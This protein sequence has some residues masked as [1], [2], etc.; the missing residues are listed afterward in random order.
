M[1]FDY[2]K[3]PTEMRNAKRWCLWKIKN[4]D[5]KP[6]KMPI[7]AY[8]GYG[9]KSN[10]ED[11]WC[12]FETA[13]KKCDFFSC[14]GLGFMLGKGFFGVDID[15]ALDNKKLINEFVMCLKSYTEISQSGEGIH[16]VCKGVLPVGARRKGNIEMYDSVRF[17]ALTGNVFEEHKNICDCTESIKEL[18]EKYLNPKPII[19]EGGYDYKKPRYQ[20]KEVTFTKFS[21]SQVINKAL[22]SQNG[23]LFNLLYY[24]QW[25]GVYK[26]QSDA[27]LAFCS[28]LAFWTAKDKVQMDDIF[29]TSKLYRAKWD[30]KH[31]QKTYGEI[32][33]D[34]AI[35]SCRDTY[36]PKQDNEKNIIYNPATGEVKNQKVY[37]LDDTGNALRFVDRFG[38]NIRYN[39]SNKYWVIWDGKTWVE[40]IRQVVKSY[41]DILI[42]EMKEDLISEQDSKTANEIFKNIKRLSSSSGK[43][44]MLKEAQHIGDIPVTNNDFDINKMLLNC[45]NGVVDLASGKLLPHDRKYMISKNTHTNVDLN[46]KCDKWID[47]LRAIFKGSE[48]MIYFIKKAVGYS[49]T[50]STKEQC[51]F[52]CHGNGSNGKSVFFNTIY[53]VFGDYVLNCQVESI[54][55]KN[56]IGSGASSD[57]A[58]MKGARFVR[59]NE[60]TEG[61]R[62]NEGLVKQLTGGDVVTARFLYGKDFEF[63]PEFK[64][65]IACNYKLVVRGTDKGIWRRMR[66][67][68]FEAC[69]EGTNDN[70]NLEEELKT[71][72]PQ[73][74]GW[75][76]QGC[77]EWQKE[78]LPVP[79]EVEIATNEYRT[80]M[81]VVEQF[82]NEKINIKEGCFREKCS[83]VFKEYSKWA[84]EGK[85]PFILSQTKFGIEMGKKFTRKLMGGC[86]YYVG[87]QLK[88]N[89]MGYNYLK[90]GEY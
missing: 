36:E 37:D 1:R 79:R 86:R 48:E 23:A 25:N 85:E 70:K 60:P 74:L 62:F 29:R 72:Y 50:G 44:A 6:T 34:K 14:D 31:G 69:F 9:A 53:N 71:M 67:I 47:C 84:I 32:T 80:E 64:L 24:G 12:D 49:L 46:G 58:R 83:D 10:D 2:S 73:I 42:N 54:V 11:T 66:L 61:M 8:T 87:V 88:K 15:H 21:N 35:S 18:Y 77:L 55:A 40:D 20:E 89:E 33:L 4:I 90:Q 75:A 13:Y 52:Q 51:F 45:E 17:F 7:N 76:I 59:T 43:E 26:S 68:P 5:G 28:L 41:A 16:I 19:K 65:W 39:V 57:I 82:C 22:E 78:G 38:S 81:D 3:I 30:E 27:D 56:S 63:R